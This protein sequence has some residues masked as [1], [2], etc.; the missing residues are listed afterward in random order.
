MPRLRQLGVE[1]I[2]LHDIDS[3]EGR[4]VI[5]EEVWS[6]NRSPIED[7][8]AIVLARQRVP[9]HVL[10][11]ELRAAGREASL[12]G[13]ALAPRSTLAVIHEAEALARAL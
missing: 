5:V 12:V 11:D 13:D 4:R 3:V 1:L 6:G 9:R 7:V 8:D 2:A 10:F